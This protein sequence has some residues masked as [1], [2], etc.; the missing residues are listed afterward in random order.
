MH[1][2]LGVIKPRG[3]GSAAV[4]Q[5]V[6]QLLLS[7]SSTSR[8]ARLKVGHGGTLD[9]LAEGLLVVGVGRA[10]RLALPGYLSGSDKHYQVWWRVGKRGNSM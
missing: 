9:Q 3:I 6:K 1:G 10:T 8:A 5:R 2:V 4:V 7:G